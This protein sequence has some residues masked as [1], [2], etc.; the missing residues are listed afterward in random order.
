MVDEDEPMNLEI[1]GRV[2]VVT[3]ASAGIGYAVS[4][5]FLENGVSVV[6]VARDETRLKAAEAEVHRLRS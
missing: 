6:L 5:E 2:A 3:G 4:R 1:D